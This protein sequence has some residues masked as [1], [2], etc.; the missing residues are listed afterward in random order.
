MLAYAGAALPTLLLFT[1]AGQGLGQLVTGE[2]V[3][4]DD[5]GAPDSAPDEGIAALA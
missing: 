4:E 2:Q 5:S 3:A 1:V